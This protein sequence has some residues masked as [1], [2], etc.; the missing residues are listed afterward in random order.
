MRH[1]PLVLLALCA[2]AY[3]D[4]QPA[5]YDRLLDRDGPVA[6][7]PGF[8]TTRKAD[9]AHCGGFAIVTTRGKKV[10]KDDEPLAA[11]FALEFPTGLDFAKHKDEAIK[12]FQA[13]MTQMQKVGTEATQHYENAAKSAEPKV[14]LAAIARIVQIRA[15]LASVLARATIPADVRTGDFA[16]DKVNAFCDLIE[17]VATP[18][19]DA[20]ESARATCAERM[21]GQPAGWWNDAC[22]APH[23]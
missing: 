17:Q 8:A 13:W 11:V 9:A 19:S 18:M 6:G 10:A 16:K 1:A 3:G 12:K 14:K 15:R 22:A 21:Q 5:L 20:A 2:L 7:M 23:D 4:P